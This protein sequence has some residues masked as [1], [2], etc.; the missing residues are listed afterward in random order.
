MDKARWLNRRYE[1]VAWGA[2][3]IWLGVTR[4]FPGLPEGVGTLGIGAILLGLNLAR[5]LS[6][7]PTSG[8]TILLGALACVFGAFDAART[9]WR[10]ET[11]VPFFPLLLIVLGVVWLAQGILRQGK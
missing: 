4:L 5:Y 10:W 6:H 8:V 7:L 1:T 3:F 11:D 9:L 2:F